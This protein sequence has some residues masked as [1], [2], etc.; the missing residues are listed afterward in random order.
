MYQSRRKFIT[1]L[2]VAGT[3]IPFIS[4]LH[5]VSP[6][7]VEKNF[8][9]NLFS[10]PLDRYDFSFMCECAAKSGISGLDLTVRPGGKVE[11]S[12]VDSLLP[13]LVNEARRYNLSVD[14]IVT[15]I[16]SAS[17]PST[18]KILKAASGAGVKY[19]RLGWLEYRKD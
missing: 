1:N 11:P 17:D 5:S 16:T 18:E 13:E 2:A 7:L 8:T 10:K 3:A 14:M 12:M 15:G 6:L 9:I 19:Y 4:K